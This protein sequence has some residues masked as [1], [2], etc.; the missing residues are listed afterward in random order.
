MAIYEPVIDTGVIVVDTSEIKSDLQATYRSAFGESL[1]LGDETP[2]GVLIS[3]QTAER[4]AAVN[5]VANVANQINPNLAGGVYLDAIM[6]LTGLTRAVATASTFATDP[7]VTGVAGTLIPTGSRAQNSSGDLFETTTDVTLTGTDTVPFIS[8]ELGAIPCTIGDLSIVSNIVGWETVNNTVA[9]T[10]GTP[11]ASDVL[12]RTTRNNA[13]ALQGTGSRESIISSVTA[14][15]NVFSVV[16]R[17]NSQPTT[18]IV[19]GVSLDPN[20]VWVCVSGGD[21]TTIAERLNTAKNIG[22][23]WQNG[24]SSDPISIEL[25]DQYNGQTVD[26]LFDR[27]DDVPVSY[28]LTV[29]SNG[30]TNVSSVVKNAIIAYAAGEIDG[31]G[32]LGVGVDVSP[33]TATSAVNAIEPQINVLTCE[34]TKNAVVDFQPETILIE[35]YEIAS[36]AEAFIT[37]VVDP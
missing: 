25:T 20:S 5:A 4:T 12:S 3:G 16:A 32:S 31:L 21:S 17:D 35:L 36:T 8:I 2:Q 33:F 11:A 7:T 18:Q 10:V 23:Q 27:P 29:L 37:V 13:L 9:A 19:D 30:V 34:V 15:E 26:I 6:A 24:K 28:Q 22:C 1:Q 14:V